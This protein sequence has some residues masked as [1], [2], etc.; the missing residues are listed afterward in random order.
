MFSSLVD[1]GQGADA[2]NN[3]GLTLS[4]LISAPA[5]RALR[6]SAAAIDTASSRL[7][8][9]AKSTTA[10]KTP[11]MD[12]VSTA[13]PVVPPTVPEV[14]R[15][16]SASTAQPTRTV[17]MR[18]ARKRKATKRS[19][20]DDDDDGAI[21]DDD[22]FKVE[23]DDDDDG[24]NSKRKR[25]RAGA[26]AKPVAQAPVSRTTV[27]TTTEPAPG[28]LYND[29]QLAGSSERARSTLSQV[30]DV[31]CLC[32]NARVCA[33]VAQSGKSIADSIESLRRDLA[34]LVPAQSALPVLPRKPTAAQRAEV[35]VCSGGAGVA[36][37]GRACV[38]A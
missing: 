32:V 12:D 25:K 21:D 37:G 16:S 8:A 29:A 7:G 35:S 24:G 3:G 6:S 4:S 13:A 19:H 2:S 30:C 38:C 9:S 34:A 1:V 28:A 5:G 15:A 23:D 22:E 26:V 14:D 10:K 31:A 36:G 11:R 20:I 33:Q 27:S 18:E 17:P